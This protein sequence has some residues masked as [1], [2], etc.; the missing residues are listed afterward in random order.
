MGE[1]LGALVPGRQMHALIRTV[2]IIGFHGESRIYRFD[3][4]D[5]LEQGDNRNAAAFP[6]EYWFFPPDRLHGIRKCSDSRRIPAG[7]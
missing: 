1:Y 5:I 2:H 3:A 7:N 4:Q 6:S